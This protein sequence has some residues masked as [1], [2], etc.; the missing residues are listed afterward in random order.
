MRI[1]IMATERSANCPFGHYTDHVHADPADAA[2]GALARAIASN[3]HRARTDAAWSLDE[4]AT[5][6]GVSKGVVVGIEQGRANPSIATLLKIADGLGVPLT[7]LLELPRAARVRLIPPGE[8]PTLDAGPGGRL[9]LLAGTEWIADSHVELWDWSLDARGTHRSEAHRAG[10]R[11]VVHVRRGTL[12]L[13]LEGDRHLVAEGSTA[14]FT[15]DLPHEYRNTGRG[16]LEI[17]MVVL[18]P[19]GHASSEVAAGRRRGPNRS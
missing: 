15:A 13:D 16:R 19:S 17:E 14:V 9:T 3:L 5:R 2:T 10:T 12:E 11:E 4:L 6:C 7:R 8:A 1:A 18:E